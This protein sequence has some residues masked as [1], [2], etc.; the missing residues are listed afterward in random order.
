MARIYLNNER[1][2]IGSTDIAVKASM[3]DNEKERLKGRST[4]ALSTNLQLDNIQSNLQGIFRSLVYLIVRNKEIS[5]VSES[6]SS[7]TFSINSSVAL[8]I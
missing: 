5:S 3:W 7:I 2:S 6:L 4:E 8:R 1:I